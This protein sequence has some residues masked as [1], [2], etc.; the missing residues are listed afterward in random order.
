M[1]TKHHGNIERTLH[2]RLP[3]DFPNSVT[4]YFTDTEDVRNIYKLCKRQALICFVLVW[5]SFIVIVK[6]RIDLFLDLE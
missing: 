2:A 4:M 6:V 5:F 3:S 1:S